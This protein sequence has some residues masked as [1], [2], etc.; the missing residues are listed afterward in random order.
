MTLA[1]IIMAW[2]RLGPPP[3][4]RRHGAED[5]GEETKSTPRPPG[6]RHDRRMH[7]SIRAALVA[8]LVFIAAC[9]N[10]S[11]R[12]PPDPEPADSVPVDVD[13]PDKPVEQPP[14]KPPPK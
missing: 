5:R 4:P 10:G 13:N 8:S 7:R 12:P 1:L 9:R 14:D 3:R 11:C 2:A 6:L